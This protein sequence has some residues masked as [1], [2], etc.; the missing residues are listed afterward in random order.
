MMG[1][2]ISAA[3]ARAELAYLDHLD[4]L[5]LTAAVHSACRVFV[6]ALGGCMANAK[7]GRAEIM[8]RSVLADLRIQA[9]ELGLELDALECLP[10]IDGLLDDLA[11]LQASEAIA[12]AVEA[13]GGAND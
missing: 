9:Q 4:T 10:D 2:R 1:R 12:E 13:M 7:P 5:E 6:C 11:A 8:G 3:T